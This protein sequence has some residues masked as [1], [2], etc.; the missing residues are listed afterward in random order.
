[1]REV[2]S[3]QIFPKLIKNLSHSQINQSRTKRTLIHIQGV[4]WTVDS[5]KFPSTY[6]KQT[7]D[8]K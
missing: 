6:S 4:Y 8:G 1:M 3:F 2:Y 7:T 5:L